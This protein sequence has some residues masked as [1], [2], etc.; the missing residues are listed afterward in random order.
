MKTRKFCRKIFLLC[1][2][3]FA[4]FLVFYLLPFFKSLY[5]AFIS[6]NFHRKFVGLGKYIEVIQNSFFRLALKNTMIFS[7]FGVIILLILSLLLTIALTKTAMKSSFIKNVFLL[8]M[9]L[10][11]VSVITAW[12]TIFDSDLYFS[13][14]KGGNPILE[15]LPMYVMFIWKYTG[16]NVIILTSAFLGLPEEVLEAA[17]LDG[18][19]GFQRIRYIC[20]PLLTP[21]LF[22]VG[23]LSVVNS[24][25]IFKECFLFFETGYP[26]DAVYSVQFYMNNHFQKLNYQNLACASSIVAVLIGALIYV[27]YRIQNKAMKGVGI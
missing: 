3:G 22:F 7:T 5:Y 13:W 21:T 25:K 18:A 20:L 2:P 12:Q 15:A 10:P 24:M 6:D 8:P 23:V 14:M 9:L 16:I 26:P 27:A 4:G 17:E 19:G 11:T 1:I